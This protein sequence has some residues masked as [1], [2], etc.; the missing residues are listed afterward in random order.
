MKESCANC[1]LRQ[2]CPNVLNGNMRADSLWAKIQTGGKP[3]KCTDWT[4][5]SEIGDNTK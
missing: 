4:D 3:D 1:S 2:E 5:E